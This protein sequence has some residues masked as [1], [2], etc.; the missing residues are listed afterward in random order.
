MMGKKYNKTDIHVWTPLIGFEKT[1]SDKGAGGMLGRIPFTP[2]AISAFAYHLDI[3]LQHEGMEKEVVLPPDMCS[4]YASERN[5]FRERQEWTNYDLRELVKNIKDAGSE[6]YLNVMANR[7]DNRY[8]NE[9]IYEHP[10]IIYDVKDDK[11]AFNVF[12]RFKDGSYFEDFFIEKLCRTLTDYGF[13]GF[14]PTDL[15]CPMSWRINRGDFSGD[16]TEQ[17]S[18]HTGIELPDD[19]KANLDD[20]CNE[21]KARRGDWLWEEHRQEWIEFYAWRWGVFWKKVCDRVHAIGKKIMSLGVYCTDPFENYYCMGIDLK[22]LAE[23]GIDIIVPNVVPTGMRLQH[24]DWRDPY[25]N[26]MYML[27]LISSFIPEEKLITMLGVRDDTEEWDLIHHAPCSLERDIYMMTSFMRKDKDGYKRCTDGFLVCLGDSLREEDWEWLS[28][29]F[30]EG[31]YDNAEKSE[32]PTVI[33]SDNAFYNLLPEYIKTKRWTPHKYLYELANRGTLVSAFAKIENLDSVEGI[34]FVPNFDMLSEEEKKLIAGYDRG[35]VVCTA[36]KGFN[37]SEYGIK[38]DI[39]FC[40]GFSSY[41]AMAFAFNT[42]ISEETRAEIKK[43]ISADDNTPDISVDEVGEY[44][45]TIL[46]ETLRFTKVT[47]GFANAVALLVKNTGTELFSS[48]L[49]ISVMKLNNGKYRVSVLNPS[50]VAYGYAVVSAKKPIKSVKS[51]SQYPVL[52]V[53]LLNSPTQRVSF[54]QTA[55]DG[56]QCHFRVKST[57]GGMCV[58]EVELAD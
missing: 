18:M 15:F 7:H 52:P 33:W 11:G 45:C 27:P 1:D 24:P 51:V 44:E 2:D 31:I 43:L 54:A 46:C 41:S 50:Y 38:T 23:S 26:Y 12:R 58:L 56:T 9:W 10:E 32:S 25:F 49:P 36:M 39:E 34:L 13:T 53:K 14:F 57:P 29:R 35:S 19:I 28:N 4:Y 20:D 42:Q 17:F 16:I 3:V 21:N 55:S 48:N 37:P 5:G 47:D 8:H 30:E 40:D 22:I 6:V